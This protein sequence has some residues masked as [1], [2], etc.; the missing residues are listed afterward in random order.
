M[1]SGRESNVITSLE[2]FNI[3]RICWK[4]LGLDILRRDATTSKPL[5]TTWL[6]ILW[7]FVINLIATCSF[8]VH[9]SLGILQR[10]TQ[11]ILFDS[12]SIAITSIGATIK[13]SIVASKM[14]KIAEMEALIRILDSRVTHREEL[15]H[16]QRKIRQS[17]LNIQRIYYVVYL[18]V[19]VSAV[20]AFLFSK[21]RRLFY[22]GWLPFDWRHS[23]WHYAAA[24]AYQCVC[25][26]FQ[27]METFSNDSFSP[28]ALCVL[29]A[30]IKLLY[31]R[32]AR[33]GCESPSAVGTTKTT[34]QDQEDELNLC[35]LDQINL[36]K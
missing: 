25:I 30:H 21:E 24:I 32:V 27:I 34:L 29:S 15:S 23:D 13:F 7:A 5:P 16:Y 2:Y 10:K 1:T 9:L 20:G 35:V 8:P 6:Y 3:N 31:M 26:F 14:K 28:K 4:I 22:P 17:I 12:I 36:Y 19:G 11:S 18:A 33:I